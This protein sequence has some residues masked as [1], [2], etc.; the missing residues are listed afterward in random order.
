VQ[1]KCDYPR[2]GYLKMI[3]RHF[4]FKFYNKIQGQAPSHIYKLTMS[5]TLQNRASVLFNF[6]NCVNG[7]F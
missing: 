2:N 4:K 1:I 3:G 6:L 5:N 7:L